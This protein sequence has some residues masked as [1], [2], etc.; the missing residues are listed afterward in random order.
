M[1]LKFPFLIL[2]GLSYYGAM[3]QT[4]LSLSDAVELAQQQSVE[5]KLAGNLRENK[6]YAW[7]TFRATLRPQ[8]ALQAG[9]PSYR[10]DFLEVRQP[11]GGIR[12][13]PRTQNNSRIGLSLEQVITGT[14][15]RLSVHADLTR[16]DDFDRK[17][18]SYSATPLG[19]SLQQ[20]ILGF[21]PYRWA[22]RIEPLKLE[23][24]G[25]AYKFQMEEIALQ[26]VQ[27]FFDVIDARDAAG[28]AAVNLENSRLIKTIE[29]HRIT[30]G[31]TTR[32]KLLQIELQV[33]RA[34]QGL[35]EAQADLQNAML[36][37]QA[38]LG[39][40]GREGFS[41]VLPETIP[42]GGID[43]VL[44]IEMARENRAEFIAFERRKLESERAIEEA[45]RS[46]FRADLEVVLGFNGAGERFPMVFSPLKDQQRISLNLFVPIMD[47]GR[48]RA[49]EG[50][51]TANARVV[52][53]SIEQ[54]EISLRLQI[55][56]QVK[57]LEI[58]GSNIGYARSGNRIGEERYQL[59]LEQYHLGK[60][61]VGD[62]NIAIAEK[63]I[64]HRAYLIALRRYWEAYYQMRQMTLYDFQSGHKI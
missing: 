2:L 10:R 12:F 23:E 57:R 49:Q 32:E 61:S 59:A 64:A 47:W 33:L 39:I 53:Y 5:A 20:P 4:L 43:S 46:R 13:L 17:V 30:L 8:L 31:T 15:G 34:A 60:L 62:L 44:A 7:Q 50:V 51:A 38:F 24:A 58:L 11:D 35:Q 25:K 40:Q 26:A 18:I 6:F 63:D 21:N 56:G 52:A 28:T 37:L 45:Q 55:I 54:E 9:L 19:L 42:A 22:Q 1:K 41:P 48:A 16:F 27:L 3:A 29:E 14:G 36:R